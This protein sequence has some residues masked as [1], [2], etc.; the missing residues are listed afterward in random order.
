M[1]FIILL[2]SY[3]HIFEE[4]DTPST[5]LTTNRQ[6]QTFS[7]WLIGRSSRS[8]VSEHLF[9]KILAHVHLS[10]EISVHLAIRSIDIGVIDVSVLIHE[11]H[12]RVVR[13][14]CRIR[15]LDVSTYRDGTRRS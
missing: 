1:H 15:E 5:I 3:S 11:E 12:A 13:S 14:I 9:H 8:C 10:E 6:K 4:I 2:F 7:I